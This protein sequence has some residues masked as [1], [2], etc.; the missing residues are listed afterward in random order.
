[1]ATVSKMLRAFQRINLNDEVAKAIKKRQDLYLQLNKDQ[2]MIGEDADAK[3]L[4]PYRS[5]SYAE[6]KAKMN[7]LPGIGTPD[8]RLSGKLYNSMKLVFTADTVDVISTVPYFEDIKSRDQRAFGLSRESKA[9]LI[10][11]YL[12]QQINQQ[13]SDKTGVGLG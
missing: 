11:T 6:L 1:M 9:E 5:K 3:K 2:L 13:I 8:Y 12:Q 4:P 10:D 7:T